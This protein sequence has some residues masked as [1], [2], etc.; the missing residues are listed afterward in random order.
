MDMRTRQGL[1]NALVGKVGKRMDNLLV[2]LELLSCISRT[3][4][5]DRKAY[6]RRQK[7]QLNML[8]EVLINHPAVGFGEYGRKANEFRILLLKIE[9]S[10][11]ECLRSL[12]ENAVPLAERP[13]RGDLTGEVCHWADGYHLNVKLYEKLLFSVYDILDEVKLTEEVEEMRELI[14]STWKILGIS[15]HLLCIGIISSGTIS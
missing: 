9:E 3:E 13:I 8:E 11:T 5:S 15:L 4:F 1:L 7:R 12:R 2:P 6:L 10:E 14:T